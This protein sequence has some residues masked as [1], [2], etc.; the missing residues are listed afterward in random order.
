[1]QNYVKVSKDK[2]FDDA[3]ISGISASKFTTRSKASS[4]GDH[5]DYGSDNSTQSFM[6]KKELEIQ[7]LQ[8]SA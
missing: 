1:M 6:R 8:K 3:G 5:D 2:N 7:N 4:G